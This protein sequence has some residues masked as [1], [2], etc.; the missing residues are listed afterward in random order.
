MFLT[1]STRTRFFTESNKLL[2]IEREFLSNF[3]W[4]KKKELVHLNVFIWRNK[5]FT[6]WSLVAKFDMPSKGN[7]WSD[8]EAPMT[9]NSSHKWIFIQNSSEISLWDAFNGWSVGW[10]LFWNAIS[11]WWY[12]YVLIKYLRNFIGKCDSFN[13]ILL[14]NFLHQTDVKSC[15]IKDISL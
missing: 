2:S 4:T 8:N 7:Q 9:L 1:F 15:S 11:C 10:N 6:N 14:R 3:G 12:F 5:K 13:L